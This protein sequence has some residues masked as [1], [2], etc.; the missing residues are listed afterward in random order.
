MIILLP[1]SEGKTPARS[2]RPLDLEALSFAQLAPERAQVLTALAEASA[3]PDALLTLGVG[4]SLAADVERNTHLRTEHAAPAIQTYTGVLYGALGAADLDARAR[5]RLSG[6]YVSSALFGIVGARDRIPAYR[7][8]MK[9]SL[10]PLGGLAAWWRPRL[11]PVLDDAFAGQLILDCRSAEYRRAWPGPPEAVVTVEAVTETGGKRKVISHNAKHARGALAG[12]L[13]RRAGRM[14]ATL[15][16]LESA[17]AEAFRVELRPPVGA[18]PAVL[19]LVVE[20]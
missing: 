12:H 5:R 13:L 7:L 9:T 16:A 19:T 4:P 15:E 3:A 17:A 20:G 6:V 11:A 14:P 2:G 1:P 8:A 10:P 18:Q